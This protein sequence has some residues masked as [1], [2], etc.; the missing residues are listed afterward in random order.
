MTLNLKLP[1]S[2][3]GSRSPEPQQYPRGS[4][5]PPS[6]PLLLGLL[7]GGRS[8]LALVCPSDGQTAELRTDGDEAFGSADISF[9]N[10]KVVVAVLTSDGAWYEER[11]QTPGQERVTFGWQMPF[12]AMWRLA[13]R[14]SQTPYSTMFC[15]TESPWFDTKKAFLKKG[16]PFAEE[17]ELGVIYLYDRR[18]RTPPETLTPTDIVQD[19]LGIKATA[20]VLDTEGLTT[21]RT[22]TGW[23]TWA[24][25]SCT[26]QSLRHVF[27]RG[28]EVQEK[29][30][31]EHLCDDVQPFLEGMD[32]R[33]AEYETFASRIEELCA[34]AAG[35]SAAGRLVESVRQ[36]WGELHLLLQQRQ[37]LKKPA[38]AAE[39]CEKIKSLAQAKSEESQAESNAAREGIVTVAGERQEMLRSCRAL[40]KEIRDQ[41][42][43]ACLRQPEVRGLADKIRELCREVL[44]MRYIVEDDWRGEAHE[45][46]PFWLG[47]RAQDYGYHYRRTMTGR[48]TWQGGQQ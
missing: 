48:S 16:E 40:V 4:C 11:P 13:V 17:V 7:E 43:A 46:P 42:G 3:P 8:V 37:G 39:F 29:V 30:F 38:E 1:Q 24:D 36:T 12:P 41:A 5:F 18:E 22:A 2:G 21:Y 10:D 27:S 44:R 9:G 33:L 47:P 19:A 20:R 35:G 6:A 45:V 34:G 32:Q 28:L 23:T 15:E 14:G 25:L 31:V 26:L